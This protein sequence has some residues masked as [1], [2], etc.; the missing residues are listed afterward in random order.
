MRAFNQQIEI[1]IRAGDITSAFN[2]SV[3]AIA[4]AVQLNGFDNLDTI[5][6][7]MQLSSLFQNKKDYISAINH[8]LAAKYLVLLFGGP[9]HPELVNIYLKLASMYFDVGAYD[10]GLSCLLD[11]KKRTEHTAP[12]KHC[13]ICVDLAAVLY[14]LSQ[15]GAAAKM[16]KDAYSLAKKLFTDADKE[17]KL[18]N[19]KEQLAV[20]LRVAGE[21][22]KYE[23]AWNEQQAVLKA[24]QK[25]KEDE[26]EAKEEAEARVRAL[27]AEEAKTRQ[28]KGNKG[29]NN[30]SNNNNK[31]QQQGQKSRKKK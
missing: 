7:H 24:Q 30:N 10:T 2:N 26:I 14:R 12:L 16:Q 29:N 8:L 1:L 21:A 9:R 11:A 13:N 18:A 6:C 4:T 3:R 23:K 31:Q 28:G 17:S 15:Y 27:L 25:A 5:R 20:Y 22:A 19:I